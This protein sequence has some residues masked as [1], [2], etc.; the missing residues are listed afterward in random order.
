MEK[1][2]INRELENNCKVVI[3]LELSIGLD[4]GLELRLELMA[5]IENIY[6]IILF[7]GWVLLNECN[8]ITVKC[9][10]YCFQ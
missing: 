6:N 2:T 4:I 9:L 1:L 5:Y 3:K 8:V 10:I 7:V